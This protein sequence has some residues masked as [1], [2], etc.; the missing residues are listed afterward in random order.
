MLGQIAQILMLIVTTHVV[1]V[2]GRWVGPRRGALLMGVPSTT[3][4][5]L[6]GMGMRRGLAEAAATSEAC[7]VGLVAASILPLVYARATAAGWRWPTS[8]ASGIVGYTLV[9]LALWWLPAFGPTACTGFAT[10]GLAIACLLAYRLETRVRG[11]R[12][13]LVLESRTR[14]GTQPAGPSL[15]FRTAVPLLY[16]TTL[17]TVRSLAGSGFSGRFITFPGA[18]LAILVTTHLE[19][20]PGDACRTASAM[21]FG[22]LGMLAFLTAFR[23]GCPR[24]GLGWGTALAYFAA[25]ATLAAVAALSSRPARDPAARRRPL[26]ALPAPRSRKVATWARARRPRPRSWTSTHSRRPITWP[27]WS[28]SHAVVPLRLDR[29]PRGRPPFAPR[30]EALAG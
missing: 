29:A 30:L 19:A 26:A 16:F 12:P 7:M 25:L 18:S 27:E 3:A 13:A 22:G 20:G 15:T 1:R 8:A 2:V 9:A 17:Q 11:S 6:F 10:S 28:S 14:A 24:I 5:V 21:P 23:F 4:V